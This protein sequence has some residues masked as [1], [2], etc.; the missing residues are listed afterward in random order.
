ME[1]VEAVTGA[2]LS[3]PIQVWG[4]TLEIVKRRV[5]DYLFRTWF[6]PLVAVS[7]DGDCIGLQ[8][9]D[10]FARDWIE[11]H[12]RHVIE[13]AVSEAA[14]LATFTVTV[15]PHL[16][17]KKE[18]ESEAPVIVAGSVQRE[19][20]RTLNDRYLFNNFVVGPSNQFA[21][22]ASRAVADKPAQ[23]YNPLFLF[24]GVGLGKTHL[25]NAIGHGI[26]QQNPGFRIIY[27]SSEQFMN[28]VINGIRYNKMEELHTKYR[29]NCDVLLM[30]DIQLIAGKDRTQEEFFHT[31]NTLFESKRQIVVSS[32]KL[33]HEIPG[34]EERTRSRF[35]WGLI[36][37]IQPPEIET[38]IAILKK[39]AELENIDL[40][41]EVAMFLGENIRS[42]VRELEGALI[43][44]VA[45]S[46]LTGKR[47][48]I[49]YAKQVLQ[50][51]LQGRRNLVTIEGIQKLVATYYN[52]KVS[53]LKSQRRHRIVAKPRQVAMYLCRKV[54]SISYPA[55]GESFGG[56]DHT[57][58]LSACRKMEALVQ[59]DHAIRG[60]IAEIQRK[61]EE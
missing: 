41:D 4:E 35:Q 44:V 29:K 18:G 24:G 43:R 39:K 30:D 38:R 33:P 45:H 47:I 14:G 49:D 10:R 58:I 25:I 37:D 57:T 23:A 42:N 22:A 17:V 56:K 21:F 28:E 36:A 8:I 1:Q 48:S 31:F 46:S 3:T 15:N 5:N 53:D 54:L 61:I 32:D 50:E 60:E 16:A 40:P 34:L 51:I 26:L 20:P 12:Y 7:I 52:V 27:I 19:Q 2:T 11:D 55:L 13:E 6:E 9:H 59:K